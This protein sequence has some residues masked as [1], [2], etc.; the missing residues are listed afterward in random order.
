MYDARMS[1][2]IV[3]AVTDLMFQPRIEAAARALGY[4]V[5]APSTEEAATIALAASPAGLVVDLHDRTF[6]VQRLI[7]QAKAAGV[8]V[9]AFGRHTEPATLRAARQAGADAAVPRSQLVDELPAL[10]QDLV[11]GAS[12]TAA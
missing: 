3:V 4:A 8:R 12:G 6:D 2:T 9:L 5:E 10:L 1:H 11:D 7:V